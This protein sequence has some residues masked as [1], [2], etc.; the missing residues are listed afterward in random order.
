[1]VL[2]FLGVSINSSQY[3][4]LVSALKGK[5]RHKCREHEEYF[6]QLNIEGKKSHKNSITIMSLCLFESCFLSILYRSQRRY[7]QLTTIATQVKRQYTKISRT[8]FHRTEQ[9]MQ[10]VPK[11]FSVCLCHNISLDTC[12]KRSIK[13][14]I[15][16]P[17]GESWEENLWVCTMAQLLDIKDN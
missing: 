12:C 14:P 16:V 3:R 10:S 4:A 13:L 11:H 7:V 6:S 9:T 2:V 17:V 5:T 1:M 15:Y 8:E